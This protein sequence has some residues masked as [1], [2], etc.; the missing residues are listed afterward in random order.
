L[1]S[2]PNI[3]IGAPFTIG[4]GALTSLSTL[5]LDGLTDRPA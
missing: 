5:P 1:V 3:A 2:A 4:G